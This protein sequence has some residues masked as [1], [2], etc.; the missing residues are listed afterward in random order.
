MGH[1]LIMAVWYLAGLAAVVW[2]TLIPAHL[3]AVDSRV[4]E[5]AGRGTRGL[6]VDA[7]H[8]GVLERTGT[9]WTMF[10]AGEL[11]GVQPRPGL[12]ED[13]GSVEA[14]NPSLKI[15]G[16]VEPALSVLVRGIPSFEQWDGSNIL[17]SLI[18]I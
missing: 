14:A 5:K 12:A 16:R 2:A 15:W 11:L 6:M 8:Y 7:E 1:W 13:I 18:H 17:L 9:S 4:L 3:R 10:R